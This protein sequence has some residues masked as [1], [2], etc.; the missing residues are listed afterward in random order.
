L[1]GEG[2]QKLLVQQRGQ[3]LGAKTGLNSNNKLLQRRDTVSKHSNWL[4]HQN[5]GWL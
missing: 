3:Q 5:A 4:Y 1:K 2:H